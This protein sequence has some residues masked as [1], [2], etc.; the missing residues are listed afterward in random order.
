MPD[1]REIGARAAVE[2]GLP[3][4]AAYRAGFD[5]GLSASPVVDDAAIERR[6]MTYGDVS[7]LDEVKRAVDDVLA[8]ADGVWQHANRERGFDGIVDKMQELRYAMYP[9]TCEGV[10]D[11][12]DV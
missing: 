8:L 4:A 5:D 11:G 12:P 10:P 1:E 3:T 7:T 6:P 2:M 9:Q